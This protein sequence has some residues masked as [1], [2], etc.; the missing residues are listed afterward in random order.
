MRRAIGPGFPILIKSSRRKQ[1]DLD[2]V[3]LNPIRPSCQRSLRRRSLQRKFLCSANG[4]LPR[5]CWSR[6]MEARLMIDGKEMINND[7]MHYEIKKENY[8]ALEKG[9]HTFEVLYFDYTR[10]ETLNIRMGT[11]T[12]E[13]HDFNTY[14]RSR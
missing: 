12:G 4:C 13:M 6:T 5:F 8:V 3:S 2:S 10:R 14:V 11:Q 9:L 1:F 7:G